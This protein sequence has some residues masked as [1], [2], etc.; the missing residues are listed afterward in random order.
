MWSNLLI[1]NLHCIISIYDLI[2]RHESTV[3]V[4]AVLCT[5]VG[6]CTGTHIAYSR[7]INLYNIQHCFK[8][9]FV[10][11]LQD[12]AIAVVTY[13]ASIMP[14]FDIRRNQR[15]YQPVLL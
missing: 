10:Y 9:G 14:C 3:A 6:Y 5:A 13:K 1:I 12:R 15:R 2:T 7:D 11:N 4:C 8:H